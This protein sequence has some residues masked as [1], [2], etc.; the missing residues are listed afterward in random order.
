MTPNVN[1]LIVVAHLVRALGHEFCL[2]LLDEV[3]EKVVFQAERLLTHHSLHR[4]H[5]LALL[6]RR[7]F[8]GGTGGN[9]EAIGTAA[10]ALIG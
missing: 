6:C 3:K 9:V 1:I 7:V 5:V 2:E 4:H 10:Y 8:R